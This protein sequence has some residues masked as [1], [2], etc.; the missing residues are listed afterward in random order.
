[1]WFIKLRRRWLGK[2]SCPDRATRRPPASLRVRQLET[3]LTPSLVTLA[4]FDGSDGESPSG[5]L[6]IDGNGNLYGTTIDGGASD[7][8]TVFELA[9]GSDTITTLASFDGT[10]GAR[11]VGGVVLDGGGNLYGTTDGGG[12]ANHG[13]VFELAHGSGTITA[14]A[15]FR[16]RNGSSPDAGVILDSRGNLYGTTVYGGA[17]G[18]TLGDGTIFEL[19]RGSRTITTLASFDGTGAENPSAGLVMDGG[20]NLYGTTFTLGSVFELAA[21]SDTLTTLASGIGSE[22]SLTLDSAGNLYGTGFSGGPSGFGSVFELGKGS[23]AVTTLASFSGHDG[24]GR[25]PSS[26]LVMDGSGDLYGTAGFA[27]AGGHGTVFELRHGRGTLTALASF[28]YGNGGFPNA[29]LVLDGG[30]NLYGTTSVGGAHGDGTI[31]ELPAVALTTDQ[32]TGA[33]F[34]V[35]N[36]WSDGANWSL[37]APPS[38]GQTVVFNDADVH[39]LTS[40]VDAG[41]SNAIGTLHIAGT[42]GGTITVNNP[43]TVTGNF[44]MASGTFGGTGAVTI[45]GSASRWTGGQ[46][47][48]GSGGFTNEGTLHLKTGG[49]LVLTDLGTMTNDG[50]IDLAGKSGLVLENGATL[51]NAS[52]ATFNLTGNGS[53]SQSGGGAF[54]NAGTLEKS[55]GGGTS[56][57]ATTGLDNTGTVAVTGGRLDIA[58]AVA[59]VSNLPS[60]PPSS[61][62]G[63]DERLCPTVPQDRTP[64]ARTFAPTRLRAHGLRPGRAVGRT[65]LPK[66]SDTKLVSNPKPLRINS[67]TMLITM[68]LP[69]LTSWVYQ[70]T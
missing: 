23:G 51:S 21:G 62:I 35:D 34:T 25:F 19:A 7:D 39:S 45:G 12:A 54:V 53:V 13:T 28:G 38:P 8:G 36:N 14:L 17:F 63:R 31:Y 42:W 70:F 66:N 16:G 46:I 40:T 69:L 47:D 52:G 24:A 68:I 58:A 41:F 49:S 6:A 50:T 3:R 22:G 9:K 27:G 48:L 26:G 30:G 1:M 64:G 44:S 67:E 59:Q 5:S 2:S 32:W 15:S 20:G 29:G 55:G 60:R 61:R 11:P 37:G 56:T 33:N 4:S 10:D 57:V 43:L 18:G 65:S